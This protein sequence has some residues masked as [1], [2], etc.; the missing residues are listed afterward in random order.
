MHVCSCPILREQYQNHVEQSVNR[1]HNQLGR[2]QDLQRFHVRVQ[3]HVARSA[4]HGHQ[5]DG[6]HGPSVLTYN[7]RDDKDRCG[8]CHGP[9]VLIYN[10]RD[11]K[12][13]YGGCHVHGVVQNGLG[14]RGVVVEEQQLQRQPKL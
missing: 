1:G 11:D 7:H 9:S 3:I 2:E 10:H 8:E 6:R 13:R 14:L 4:H 5:S 12:D